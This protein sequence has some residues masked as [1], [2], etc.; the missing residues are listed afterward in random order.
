MRTEARALIPAEFPEIVELLIDIFAFVSFST[1]DSDEFVL[2]E[3]VLFMME[4]PIEL[5]FFI[6]VPSED[7]M[8]LVT[9]D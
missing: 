3:I 7:P 8:L 5:L 4:T 1:A 6:P 2:L 9:D